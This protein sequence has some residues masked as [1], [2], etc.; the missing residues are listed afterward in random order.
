MS[1][2]SLSGLWSFSESPYCSFIYMLTGLPASRRELFANWHR[3]I[4]LGA[5]LRGGM[6]LAVQVA[7]TEAWDGS[8]PPPPSFRDQIIAKRV[9]SCSESVIRRD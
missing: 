4:R 2:V 9:M 5:D 1:V 6:H 7:C 8:G 3:N